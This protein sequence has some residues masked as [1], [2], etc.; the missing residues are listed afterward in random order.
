MID[1]HE[2]QLGAGTWLI[3]LTDEGPVDVDW[4]M[5]LYSDERFHARQDAVTDGIVWLEPVGET[6]R[7]LVT[8]PHNDY[9]CLAVWK[10]HVSEYFKPGSYR[11]WAAQ[12]VSGVEDEIPV[13]QATRI[14]AATP[15]PFNPQTTIAFEMKQDGPCHL[16]LYDLQGR[17][18]RT[19]VA[20]HRAAG[21]GEAVWDGLDDQGSRAASGV[22]LARL[23][24][25]GTTDL[26]KVTLVK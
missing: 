4:G 2:C 14:T 12:G 21:P 11:L 24:A 1:L 5:S 19:L 18:V 9:Y 3:T 26:L 20:E 15:N 13:P 17:L 16:A 25:A 23:R 7:M 22:Y 8:V 10:T 6:E